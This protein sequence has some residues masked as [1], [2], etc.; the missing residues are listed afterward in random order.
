MNSRCPLANRRNQGHSLCSGRHHL[1]RRGRH[2]GQACAPTTHPT[3]PTSVR[4]R[5]PKAFAAN[6]ASGG[7][8][9]SPATRA[10]RLSTHP[11]LPQLNPVLPQ[12][13]PVRLQLNP[14]RLQLNPVL[15]QLN[16]VLPQ[17]NGSRLDQRPNPRHLLYPRHLL[18]HRHRRRNLL[19]YRRFRHHN[20]LC[21]RS[22]RLHRS[23][24]RRRRCRHRRRCRQRRRPRPSSRRK[25]A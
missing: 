18:H 10:Q 15:P 3:R 17:L 5:P 12:L 21:C 1:R 23:R 8:V 9:L 11:V 20:L 19:F 4:S 25:L 7:T 2:V 24:R 22:H 14:V 13:N 6:A 16:P